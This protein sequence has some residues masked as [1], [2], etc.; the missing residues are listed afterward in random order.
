MA[1][2]WLFG[3]LQP[4]RYSPIGIHALIV[5]GLVWLATELYSARLAWRAI[6]AMYEDED[7]LA[8][9]GADRGFGWCSEGDYDVDKLNLSPDDFRGENDAE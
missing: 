7:Y 2:F 9:I 3:C 4:D 6:N 8:A 5:V 1:A